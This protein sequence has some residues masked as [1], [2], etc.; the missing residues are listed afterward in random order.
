VLKT[1]K[2]G[3]SPSRWRQWASSLY[4][5]QSVPGFGTLKSSLPRLV[6]KYP[7]SWRYCGKSFVPG[8][9]STKER[10]CCAPRLRAYMPAAIVVRAGAH[11][12]RLD[13]TCR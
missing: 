6:V 1:E 13:Q 3:W 11:T 7:A 10:M 12:G 9:R 8:G 4:S 2:K 5:S